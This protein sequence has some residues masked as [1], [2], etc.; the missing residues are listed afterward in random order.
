M[1][2]MR[3]SFIPLVPFMLA[4]EGERRAGLSPRKFRAALESSRVR[5]YLCL[6]AVEA[7]FLRGAVA[8]WL[9][10][11]LQNRHTWVQ[12]PSAPPR[13]RGCRSQGVRRWINLSDEWPCQR[14][15]QA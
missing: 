6:V 11:G 7:P 2:E 15:I 8:K 9:G 3:P 1:P 12:I 14:A 4:G 10:N 13:Q 5:G